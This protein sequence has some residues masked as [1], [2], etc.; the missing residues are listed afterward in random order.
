VLYKFGI[1]ENRRT[2]E[3]VFAWF[4]RNESYKFFLSKC[5]SFSLTIIPQ[6][7]KPSALGTIKKHIENGDKVIIISA[8]FEDYL[9]DWCRSMNLEILGTRIEIKKGFVTGRIDGKNCYG[10]E[11]VIRLKQFL[12]LS[13]FDE[14]YAYGDSQS[15][16]P[17]LEIANHRFYRYFR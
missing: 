15:D 6:L 14:I 11:K 4:F 3:M 7:I 10:V 12:D 16:K 2:K 1:I 9:T 5:N 17:L 8:S 13:Q